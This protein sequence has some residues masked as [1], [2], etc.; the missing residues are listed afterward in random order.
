M[1]LKRIRAS[2]FR[3]F[4]DSKVAPSLDWELAPGLNIFVGENDSGKPSA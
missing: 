3:A 1:H 4:G 2:N